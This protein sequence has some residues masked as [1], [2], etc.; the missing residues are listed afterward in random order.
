MSRSIVRPGSD[1]NE[2]MGISG[3]IAMSDDLMFMVVTVH[4]YHLRIFSADTLD[5]AATFTHRSRIL[6]CAISP[7]PQRANSYHIMVGDAEGE[8]LFLEFLA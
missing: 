4:D 5:I 8:I 7:D 2:G 3:H 6:A 1:Y